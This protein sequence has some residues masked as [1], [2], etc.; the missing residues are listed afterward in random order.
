MPREAE[1]SANEKAFVTQAL[2]ENLRL[3]GRQ[4]DEYRKI[5]LTFGDEYGVADVELGK[6]RVLVKVSAEVTVPY[7][8]RPFEG[9]FQITTELSPMASPA[10]EVN[11]PTEVEVLLARLLEK[12]VRRSGALDTES[13]CLVAGQKVWS[14]RAD[15]HVLSHDGNLTDASCLAVVAALRHFRKP[16]TSNEGESLTIFTAAEREPVPLSWLHSP[17][18]VTFS[19]FGDDGEIVLADASWLEEQLRTSSVTV[20]LN[21]HGEIS[22][23]S[24]LGGTPVEALTLLQCG[25]LAEQKARDFSALVDRKLAED[26]KRRDKGGLISELLS[27]EN[28]RVVDA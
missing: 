10:F 1:P 28:D 24:K 13:L 22:Q 15:V 2:K 7:T 3:D 4:F 16:D 25:K 26:V 11:R 14:V 19:F 27:A 17:F 18:C 23:I 6:T 20:S 9:I 5:Q 12:T 8:D 21:K